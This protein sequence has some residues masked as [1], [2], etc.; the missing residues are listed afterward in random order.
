[1][2]VSMRPPRL[3]RGPSFENGTQSA[4][5]RFTSGG[6]RFRVCQQ[7]EAPH[8]MWGLFA[9]Q[10]AVAMGERICPAHRVGTLWRS[11]KTFSAPMSVFRAAFAFA[12]RIGR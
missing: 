12:D 8:S 7:S 3:G 4:E 6:S 11:P 10:P 2:R 9:F 5:E 1:M